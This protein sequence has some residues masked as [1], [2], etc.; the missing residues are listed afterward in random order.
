MCRRP[1]IRVTSVIFRTSRMTGRLAIQSTNHATIRPV[2]WLRRHSR[3]LTIMCAMAVSAGCSSVGTTS[4]PWTVDEEQLELVL[5]R[6]APAEKD[7]DAITTPANAVPEGPANLVGCNEDSGDIFDPFASRSWRFTGQAR[8]SGLDN[9][10]PAGQSAAHEVVNQL[11]ST[12]WKVTRRDRPNHAVFLELPGDG[13]AVGMTV[14]WF[15]DG[16]YAQAGTTPTNICRERADSRMGNADR[17]TL[18]PL[19]ARY[20]TWLGNPTNR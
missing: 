15:N 12:G 19:S 17:R 1:L 5:G 11:K 4:E 9:V 14:Q 7:L 10:T 6:L 8:T 13:Y 20:R 3:A 2:I 16:M 18:M